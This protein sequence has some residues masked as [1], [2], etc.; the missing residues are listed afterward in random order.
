MQSIKRKKRY[1]AL[2]SICWL[3]G[4]HP[5]L[6]KNNTDTQSWVIT[7]LEQPVHLDHVYGMEDGSVEEFIHITMHTGRSWSWRFLSPEL[8]AEH[9]AHVLALETTLANLN[10]LNEHIV[11][12]HKIRGART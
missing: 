12:T 8:D 11:H 3:M 10:A 1:E 7:V 9:I 4:C 6:V 5:K 2:A